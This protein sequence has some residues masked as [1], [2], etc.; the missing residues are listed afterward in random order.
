MG[1]FLFGGFND[2]SERNVHLD[3]AGC[4]ENIR[5]RFDRD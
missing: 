4:P 2:G 1:V 5:Q 3:I